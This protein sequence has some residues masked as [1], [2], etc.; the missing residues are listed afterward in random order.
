MIA[1]DEKDK[2]IVLIL[3][4]EHLT[5][6]QIARRINVPVAST[7]RRLQKLVKYKLVRYYYDDDG[8]KLYAYKSKILKYDVETGEFF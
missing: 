7:Y 5:L 6:T 3:R 2:K 4:D 1:I 8:K